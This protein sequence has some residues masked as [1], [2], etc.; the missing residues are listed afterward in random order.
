MNL[1]CQIELDASNSGPLDFQCP[2]IL[3]EEKIY[4]A[5][6]T[7]DKEQINE[8][9][10]SSETIRLYIIDLPSYSILEKD[11]LLQ[12]QETYKRK[13]L[14]SKLWEFQTEK[15]EFI[16]DIGLKIKLRTGEKF[17]SSDIKN[18]SHDISNRYDFPDYYL[19]HNQKS[20]ISCFDYSD[21]EKWKINIQ[22]YLYTPIQSIAN[23]L[24]WGTAGKG[25]AFYFVDTESG[26]IISEYRNGDSS[27]Y[28]FQDGYVLLPSKKGN[29][30]KLDPFKNEVLEDL[31]LKGKLFYSPIREIDRKILI[32][33]HNLN[34]ALSYLNILEIE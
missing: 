20:Q 10:F 34:K 11:I 29:L 31:K 1:V 33:S 19:S 21:E 5:Y 18:V 12:S 7:I 14:A 27:H 13:V 25:G 30:V 3:F 23:H 22:G 32:I 6:K 28:L 2:P 9:G 8:R 24:H 16:L 26:Q 15:G 4:F 17:L